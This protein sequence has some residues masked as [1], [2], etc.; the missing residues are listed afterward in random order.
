MLEKRRWF[1]KNLTETDS[2]VAG[3][4]LAQFPQRIKASALE[5]L[6]PKQE[7]IV[8]KAGTPGIPQS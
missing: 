6:F 5:Y 3:L 4:S 1:D 8:P 7:L 2:Y